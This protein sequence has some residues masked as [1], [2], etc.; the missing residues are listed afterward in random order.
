MPRI[1]AGEYIDKIELLPGRLG[2]IR[3]PANDDSVKAGYQ[4]RRALSG[5]LEWAQCFATYMAACCRNQPHRI[6][7][8]LAYQTLI[9]EVSLEYQGDGWLG[10]DWWFRQRAAGNPA[11]VWANI[12]TTPW[13]LAFAGQA[14][15]SHCCHCF[16]LSHTIDQCD[17]VPEPQPLMVPHMTSYQYLKQQQHLIL[18]LS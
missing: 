9:I 1:E 6:Q 16:C 4:R 8:L 13:N 10:Y 3:S 18:N 12:D 17:W 7:D 5:I 2:T 14:S 15:A 11:L